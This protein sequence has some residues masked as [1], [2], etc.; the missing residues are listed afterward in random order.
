MVFISGLIAGEQTPYHILILFDY[1]LLQMVHVLCLL[2]LL[3]V[4][5]SAGWHRIHGLSAVRQESLLHAHNNIRRQQGASNMEQM[6]RNVS[7]PIVKAETKLL[8]WSLENISSNS[9]SH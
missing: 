8:L 3:A 5:C 2:C 1:I 6:V 9:I 4:E 7:E